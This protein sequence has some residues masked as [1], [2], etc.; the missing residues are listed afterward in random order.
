MPLDTT[1]G[2]QRARFPLSSGEV[3]NKRFPSWVA[4]DVSSAL[5]TRPTLAIVKTLA[6]FW[7]TPN[8]TDAG[9]TII[10]D[11]EKKTVYP[12]VV[13]S[14][15]PA[16]FFVCT[17]RDDKFC[18][19]RTEDE[20]VKDGVTNRLQDTTFQNDLYKSQSNK[21][22]VWVSLGQAWIVHGNCPSDFSTSYY[23]CKVTWEFGTE[24][25]L[26]SI[27]FVSGEVTTG[28]DGIVASSVCGSTVVVRFQDARHGILTSF[29]DSFDL[30]DT[31]TVSRYRDDCYSQV[32]GPVRGF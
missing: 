4:L 20:Y 14:S 5:A 11:D 28:E 15:F 24:P 21:N 16:G 31:R 18:M 2:L 22:K 32:E 23:V 25:L 1:S 6:T 10:T 26:D 17:H 19:C 13:A 30:F 27:R 3:Y 29:T 7:T 9:T 8:I 12:Q